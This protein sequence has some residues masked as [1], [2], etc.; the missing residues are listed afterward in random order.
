MHFQTEMPAA[1]V[2]WEKP[3]AYSI[4]NMPAYY[5]SHFTPLTEEFI[6]ASQLQY[7]TTIKYMC[8]LKCGSILCWFY[9]KF[10][11]N[12]KGL[13]K[14]KRSPAII[15]WQEQLSLSVEKGVHNINLMYNQ[16]NCTFRPVFE[17]WLHFFV[18]PDLTI[19]DEVLLRNA[20]DYLIVILLR[21][22]LRT[23]SNDLI[24]LLL[25]MFETI[26]SIFPVVLPSHSQQSGFFT[27]LLY[28]ILL[29]HP[30]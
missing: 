29:F 18:L 22:M 5:H 28:T 13:F 14:L 25:Q 9:F 12:I 7:H 30:L 2:V 21:I 23:T 15:K 26:F 8:F 24:F 27:L 4:W 3:A 10:F 16:C 19:Q 17:I 1:F 11:G 6:W 20:Y